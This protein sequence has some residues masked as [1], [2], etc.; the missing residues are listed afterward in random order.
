MNK[1]TVNITDAAL[2]DMEELYNYI[3]YDLQAP[4]NAIRQYNR[5]ADS[6]LSLKDFSERFGIFKSEPGQHWQPYRR[7]S[8]LLTRRQAVILKKA[9]YLP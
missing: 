2:A 7:W 3:A 4:E 9:V 5:I 1:Y 6:I 8:M